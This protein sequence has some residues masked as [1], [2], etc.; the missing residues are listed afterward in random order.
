VYKIRRLESI[1]TKLAESNGKDVICINCEYAGFTQGTNE[2]NY[3]LN[4]EF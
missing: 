3:D 4:D 1:F 2:I